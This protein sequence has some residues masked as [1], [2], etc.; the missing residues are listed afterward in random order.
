M[1][2]SDTR[3]GYYADNDLGK[4]LKRLRKERNFTQEEIAEHL[5][6]TRQTYSHYETG[7]IQPSIS[8]LLV[9]K[10]LYNVPL[11]DLLK[12]MD[13]DSESGDIRSVQEEELI[14]Y[15]RKLTG[16]EKDVILQMIKK[17]SQ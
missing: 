12:Y 13:I 17:I 14:S 6:I 9:L 4:E 15:Y 2:V 3:M 16:K 8:I 5:H 10:T 7:R 1:K 11:S